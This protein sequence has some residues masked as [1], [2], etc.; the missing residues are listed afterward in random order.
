MKLWRYGVPLEQLG[1]RYRLEG[2]LGSGGMADVC[3]AWDERD[4]CEVAVKV[5]KDNELDQRTV[6]RFL[7][8]ASQVARWRHPHILRIFGATRFE[9][10][11]RSLG[12]MIPY[13][14]MEFAQNGDLHKRLQP[15][16]PFAFAQTLVVFEQLC[17][18][19]SYAHSQGMIH[20]D[21]KPLNILFR[22]LADGSEQMVLS[23]FGLAVEKDATHFTFASGGTLPYM[24]PEQLR[25][26]VE[27]ASDIFAL[28]VI[29]YQ[30]CTGRL[31]FRRSLASISR[32]D[33]LPPPRLPSQVFRLLPPD[34]DGVI[35]RALAEDPRQRYTDAL[36]FWDAVQE[37]VSASTIHAITRHQSQY[38]SSSGARSIQ[39]PF[40]SDSAAD[41]DIAHLPF[42]QPSYGPTARQA[43][44]AL[45][46]RPSLPASDDFEE[47]ESEPNTAR[48]RSN[49]TESQS[50]SVRRSTDL[51]TRIPPRTSRGPISSPDPISTTGPTA[52]PTRPAPQPRRQRP[53]RIGIA[54]IALLLLGLISF[55]LAPMIMNGVHTIT[56]AQ[57]GPTIT[58]VPNT[59]IITEN[60]TI[61]GVASNPD[62][63]KFQITTHTVTASKSQTQPAI[64]T[65]HTQTQGVVAKGT[66]TFF[67][68]SFAPFT[69]N[70]NIT[71]P[72]PNGTEFLTDH[73]FTI[74]AAS[75]VTGKQGAQDVPA[76]A[77]KQGAIGNITTLGINQACCTDQNF[78]TVRNKA[79]FTG[80]QDTQDYKFLQQADVDGVVN[81]VKPELT[82]Q[83]QAA[84]KANVPAGEQLDVNSVQC[85]PQAKPDQAVG[86][87]GKNI[88]SAQVSV[89]LSCSGTS[90][91]KDELQQLVMQQMLAKAHQNPGDDY[92]LQGEVTT[93]LMPNPA[94][95][96]TAGLLL[97]QGHGTWVYQVKAEQKQQL[98]R[99]VA[100][101]SIDA[102]KNIIKQQKG[103][104]NVFIKSGDNAAATLPTDPT[105]ITIQVQSS[106]GT[107]QG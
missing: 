50:R 40:I 25:G 45:A 56:G 14:V 84:L 96:I 1:G 39:D 53:W 95:S 48:I 47:L 15:G 57:T 54:L 81:Q 18:A 88:T 26:R 70:A 17:A 31:P 85:S 69:V 33:P 62:P 68:G 60:Y 30:L 99:Q 35:L 29:L 58:L 91:H 38:S 77:T 52:I 100:G 107:S 98:L 102:A 3:L 23:D 28:G 41:D 86:D 2:M 59:S 87:Q 49:N 9:L 55:L 92:Q 7:K 63:Q 67:N 37:V 10:V 93:T 20:R 66:L 42:R 22:A 8:E 21:L 106:P 13:I 16:T 46:S 74:P 101:K 78:V 11:D 12:S 36:D 44:D 75:S 43:P 79:P 90:Y 103:I 105:A 65:G 104:V 19:V 94:N 24:A 32:R 5:I 76:H 6:D 27:Q 61:Q 34:L 73:T 4:A 80:G 72:G 64:A 83:A 51:Q 89:T 71:I 82:T 97:V